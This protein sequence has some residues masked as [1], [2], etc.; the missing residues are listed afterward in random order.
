M[1]TNVP[2]NSGPILTFKFLVIVYFTTYFDQDIFCS[3]IGF[4]ILIIVKTNCFYE[5][6]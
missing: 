3:V 4:N 1:W 5:K 6:G 2:F